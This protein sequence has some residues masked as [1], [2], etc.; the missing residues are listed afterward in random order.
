MTIEPSDIISDGYVRIYRQRTDIPF[1]PDNI[2][3]IETEFHAL[4]RLHAA[5]TG[6]AKK[7][8]AFQFPERDCTGKSDTEI[9]VII[10]G[11][12]YGRT[13]VQ[14]FVSLSGQSCGNFFFQFKSTVICGDP[15]SFV[16][17]V[18]VSDC[19]HCPDLPF[20]YFRF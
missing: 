19:F 8:S 18:P 4:P 9:T 1:I 6:T 12:E 15:D 17:F 3:N 5:F 20:L 14:N 7:D 16:I 10:Q 13:I 11:I 2:L